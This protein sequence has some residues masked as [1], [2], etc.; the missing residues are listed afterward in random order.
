[1]RLLKHYTPSVKERGEDKM[2]FFRNVLISTLIFSLL[3]STNAIAQSVVNDF[4]LEL[5]FNDTEKFEWEPAPIDVDIG[6]YKLTVWI[7]QPQVASPFRGYLLTKRDWV[8]IRRR[9][10]ES[11]E[12]IERVRRQE[13][14]TCDLELDD[15]DRKCKDLNNN[16][17]KSLDEFKKQLT[18]TKNENKSLKNKSF[19]FKV[20]SGVAIG[21]VGSFAIYQT[22]SK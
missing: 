8:E 21:L 10:K 20:G 4:E 16:L 14:A 18:T 13:R 22:I 17:L 5:E 1:V 2:F 6:S 19:W 12:E 9:L 3:F 7:L 11:K 15:R